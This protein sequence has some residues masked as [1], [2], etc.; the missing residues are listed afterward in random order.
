MN[1]A[2]SPDPALLSSPDPIRGIFTGLPEGMAEVPFADLL[3]ALPEDSSEEAP[4][5][6]NPALP[7]RKL[8]TDTIDPALIMMLPFLAQQIPRPSPAPVAPPPPAGDGSGIAAEG[9]ADLQ[10]GSI[11]PPPK[12]QQ[13]I[14][15][16][17]IFQPLPAPALFPPPAGDG[18]GIVEGSATKLKTGFITPA[19]IQQRGIFVPQG[20]SATSGPS[21][22]IT[23]ENQTPFPA[24]AAG[25]FLQT[26]IRDTFAMH[27]ERP[28]FSPPPATDARAIERQFAQP[29]TGSMNEPIPTA[30]ISTGPAFVIQ[31]GADVAA[32]RTP[33]T[34]STQPILPT[35]SPTAEFSGAALPVAT[36]ATTPPNEN[37]AE[38]Q[39]NPTQSERNAHLKNAPEADGTTA[40]MQLRAM[41]EQFTERTLKAK[42]N[43]PATP[44]SPVPNR[45]T[46]VPGIASAHG[47]ERRIE[48]EPI[49]EKRALIRPDAIADKGPN[50]PIPVRAPDERG[51]PSATDATAAV[52]ITSQT[53]ELAEHVRAMGRDHVEVQMRLRGGEEVTVSLRL[54]KGEWRPVFKTESEALCQA[55]EQN[56]NRTVAQPSSLAVRFGTPVFES[57]QTQ[58]AGGQSGHPH[59]QQQPDSRDRSFDRREQEPPHRA[60]TARAT[61]PAANPTRTGAA[62]AV[63]LYA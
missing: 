1:I 46:T 17:H 23:V 31:Q 15:A 57:Q 8:A 10:G 56:W 50:V 51:A 39:G 7:P 42:T 59:G 19:A 54:E 4:S 29:P 36:P 33:A 62:P 12:Q 3:G 18:S 43:G 30:S 14:L 49:K 5:P 26:G 47:G 34:N 28:A 9:A 58:T 44:S 40:A 25:Q 35:I 27:T 2:T 63:Q 11:T 61:A 45:T 48:P 22:T 21:P 52:R 13:E 38:T 32:G 60:Q 41:P 24:S 37:P 16:Q 6:K 53:M 55:L 20:D